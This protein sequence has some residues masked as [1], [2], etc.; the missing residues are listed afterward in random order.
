MKVEVRSGHDGLEARLDIRDFDPAEWR[1]RFRE[2]QDLLAHLRTLG[3]DPGAVETAAVETVCSLLSREDGDAD[4]AFS[5]LGEVQGLVLASGLPPQDEIPEGVMFRKAYVSDDGEVDALERLLREKGLE[6]AR[7]SASPGCLVEAGQIILTFDSI[8]EGRPGMDVFGRPIPFR[9]HTWQLPFPGRG[10]VAL[11][12]K[13]VAKEAGI[14]VLQGNVLK[15]LGEGGS[16][17]E[18]VRVSEDRLKAWLP[19]RREGLAFDDADRFLESLRAAMAR[20]GLLPLRDVERV[21]EELEAFLAGGDDKEVLLLE[22]E[23]PV[24]GRDGRLELLV[25]PEPEL[26]D[27]E[28]AGRIDFRAFNCFRTVEK[29]QPLARILPPEPGRD[30][31]DV[32]GGVTPAP[33]GR[34]IEVAPGKN[35]EA[36]PRDPDLLIAG[37]AGKLTV[38]GGV[39]YVVDTLKVA[40]D[41][42]FKT[43]NLKFPGSVEVEGDVLD[44]FAIE[45][46]GDVGI[47]G[48][49]ENGVVVSEGAIVIKGGV[50]GGGGGLIK[51]KLS[52]VTIGFIRN[53]RIESHSHIVVYNEV[54]N[55]QLLARGSVTMRSAAHS[56]IGGSVTAFRSIEVFNAGNEAG[57]RTVLEVGK[58]FEVE[59]EIA[60]KREYLKSVR[61]DLEFLEG[62]GERLGVIVRWEAGANPENRLLEQRVK[63][64]AALLEKVK[65][66][67]VSS[68]ARLEEALHNPEECHILVAGTAHPGTVLKY[69]DRVIPVTEAMTRKRWV[70]KGR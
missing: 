45:A 49:V 33:A 65:Q 42:S 14:L 2:K 17:A 56:V 12:R 30:G 19:L 55:A 69:R 13:W 47:G 61:A 36:S 60:R 43:G 21:R 32:Y 39:P 20:A 62:K 66:G 5:G 3:L 27:A 41:V 8:R 4:R 40:D 6:E 37:R 59:A 58:D 54:L 24:P 18:L 52:S 57:A 22:G 70:F 1:S 23:P 44:K 35:T 68:L 34:P 26:P 48:V 16:D 53:Q 67:L 46:K 9:S 51:S 38:E 10:L 63:G 64:V 31:R 11:E 50:I 7:K 29:G 15:V 28:A 25:D